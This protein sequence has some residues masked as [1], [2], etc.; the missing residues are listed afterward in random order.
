MMKK[1]TGLT[2]S[3]HNLAK[4]RRRTETRE[5]P[6][7]RI[8]DQE[9]LGADSPTNPERGLVEHEGLQDFPRISLKTAYWKVVNISVFE[10][11]N[12][13]GYWF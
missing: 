2:R 3:L 4:S 5:E 7:D 6:R 9:D 1:F 12:L 11:I 8:P 10:R 13:L